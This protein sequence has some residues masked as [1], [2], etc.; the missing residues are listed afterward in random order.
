MT[1]R[2]LFERLHGSSFWIPL[3]LL[4]MAFIVAETVAK[5]FEPPRTARWWFAAAFLGYFALGWLWLAPTDGE[6]FVIAVRAAVIGG[7]VF[8]VARVLL[9]LATMIASR[10]IF[11]PLESMRLASERRRR[12]AQERR[13]RKEAERQ[14]RAADAQW[15]RDAPRRERARRE[16]EERRRHAASDQTRRENARAACELLY[17]A[18]APEIRTRM[19]RTE[20][21]RFM[22]TYMG[23]AKPPAEVE[24][25]GEQLRRIIEQHRQTVK[26]E[27]PPRTIAQLSEWY[28]AEKARLETLPLDERVKQDHLVQLEIRYADLTQELLEK[29]EP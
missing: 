26:P 3:L 21:D 5:R 13:R 24:R 22:A 28:L 9:P 8:H 6:L 20:V 15:R 4:T 12:D 1:V 7:I 10:L 25:R 17:A 18:H 19:P 16:E 14:R 2:E 11:E 27:R 23:D 29:M